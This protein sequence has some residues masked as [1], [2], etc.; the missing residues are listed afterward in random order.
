MGLKEQN[1][2][3]LGFT[4]TDVGSVGI[5]GCTEAQEDS[6]I[7]INR[8]LTVLYTGPFEVKGLGAGI[9]GS[10]DH[11]HFFRGPIPLWD[12]DLVTEVTNLSDDGH[13]AGVMVRSSLDSGSKHF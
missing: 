3:C 9:G 8:A 5:E 13:Q 2:I 1:G 7:D 6:V 12:I 10:Q 11:F 4:G